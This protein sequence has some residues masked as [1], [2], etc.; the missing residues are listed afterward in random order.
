MATTATANPTL[1]IQ[2]FIAVGISRVSLLKQVGNY[3]IEGQYHKLAVLAQKYGFHIPEGFLLDDE[4]YSGADF[5]RPAI[6]TALRM[7]QRGEASAVV[8]PYVDRFAR[9]VE[10]G[11]A[12]IR[13]FREAGAQ[14]L[15]G[16]F[17]WVTDEQHIKVLIR[18]YLMVAEM[19]RDSI[20][21]KSRAGVETKIA[22]GLAHGGR[23]PFGWHFV[24]A[25]ELAA[26]AVSQGRPVPEGKPQ[27]LHRPVP[28]DIGTL[29]LMGQLALEGHSA[30]GVCRELFARGIKSPDGKLYWAP[31]VA[32]AKLRDQCYSTGVWHYGKRQ[33]VAPKKLRKPDIDRHRVKSSW[34]LRPQSEWKGQP[35]LGGP[36]WTPAEQQA[37]VEALERNGK[38]NNG[39]PAATDGY[40]ALLKQLVVCSRRSQPEGKVCGYAVI[41]KQKTYRG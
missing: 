23:S 19:Q 21:E 29:R 20:A 32:A 10:G 14:V 18:I 13:R 9:N 6:R 28:E 17:G 3:S 4:G 11:L 33:G 15:F 7:V 16:E 35:L 38:V 1:K 5:N 40:E 24:T 27:N 22:K 12:L 36:V 26:E 31:N 25:L 37:I 8:F 2:P 34:K 41:P 30:R 39:K